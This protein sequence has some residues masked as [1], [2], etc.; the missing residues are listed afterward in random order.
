MFAFSRALLRWIRSKPGL[1]HR[2]PCCA[3]FAAGWALLICRQSQASCSTSQ[4]VLRCYGFAQSAS[5]AAHGSLS[6]PW[7]THAGNHHKVQT[8]YFPQT[9]SMVRFL[10]QSSSQH[11]VVRVG[12]PTVTLFGFTCLNQCSSARSMQTRITAIHCRQRLSL[13]EK[14]RGLL[15]S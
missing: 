1:W 5:A 6:L 3:S 2:V 14:F 10:Q 15:C 9:V 13:L 12:R 4:S 8:C 7:S 11:S